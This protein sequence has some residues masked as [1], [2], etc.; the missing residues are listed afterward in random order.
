M[1]RAALVEQ[2]QLPLSRMRPRPVPF[3][4]LGHISADALTAPRT[5]T[6]T[7]VL[8]PHDAPD[9]AKTQRGGRRNLAKMI[10]IAQRG[11]RAE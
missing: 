7:M 10:E 8:S 2:L 11:G 5:R 9:Q 6:P 3:H 1:T 4:D